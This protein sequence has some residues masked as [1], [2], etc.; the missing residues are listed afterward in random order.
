MKKKYMVIPDIIGYLILIICIISLGVSSYTL[1]ELK[2]PTQSS[3]QGIAIE[4]FLAKLTA[5][6]ELSDYRNIPPLNV[7]RIDNTNL[8]N[9]QAQIDGLDSSFI[10]SYVVQ[11]TG[12]L[13]IYN[14]ETDKIMANV[15]IQPQQQQQLPQDFFTK[16]FQHP[17]IK[18]VEQIAPQG[19]ILD[20]ASL[21]SLKQQL[22]DVYKDA[23]V[24][25]YL[26]RYPDR[27]I[28][29]NYQQDK[30]VNKVN[31]Q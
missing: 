26:L 3:Q 25:D 2:K 1:Y 23:Q 7:V 6:D 5:H 17:E 20:Q 29:Y 4:Q 15:P 12:R 21:Q 24:G 28:I 10:G 18:G 22:P 27:L 14:F 11:Y 30:I 16:L 13:L 8:A 19:G 9:L 31:L